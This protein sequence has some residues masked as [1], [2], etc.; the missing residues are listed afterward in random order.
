MEDG[1]SAGFPSI[2][3][4]V[5]RSKGTPFPRNVFERIRHTTLRPRLTTNRTKGDRDPLVDCLE[6]RVNAIG[7]NTVLERTALCVSGQVS[8]VGLRQDRGRL[9]AKSGVFHVLGTAVEGPNPLPGTIA[10]GLIP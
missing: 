8:A 10:A 3:S 9:S 6:S 1:A 7:E 2:R 4:S 5:Q